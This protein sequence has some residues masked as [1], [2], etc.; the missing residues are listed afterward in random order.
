MCAAVQS[1]PG[2]PSPRTYVS[3][4][5]IENVGAAANVNQSA[6]PRAA[7][8]PLS[9]SSRA[10][11]LLLAMTYTFYALGPYSS[12]RRHQGPLSSLRPLGARSSHWCIP[13]MPS[14]P[15]A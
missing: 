13:Q 5:I 8:R 14:T 7:E 1:R 11:S 12:W 4:A 9:L 6:A 15:R 3:N 10:I 2:A